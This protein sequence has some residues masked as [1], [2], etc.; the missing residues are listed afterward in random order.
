M[1]CR[2]KSGAPCNLSLRARRVKQPSANDLSPPFERSP[3]PIP[4]NLFT[5][6]P[7]PH[8]YTFFGGTDEIKLPFSHVSPGVFAT[9]RKYRGGTE[10][11]TTRPTFHCTTAGRCS[12]A[13]QRSG[14]IPRNRAIAR[15]GRRGMEAR[16][17]HADA[18]ALV[19]DARRRH[20]RSPPHRRTFRKS[21]YRPGREFHR[22][23]EHGSEAITRK[24]P[25]LA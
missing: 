17:L 8:P 23:L 10:A 9:R 12:L 20:G 16:R 18:N 25:T 6:N 13:G 7:L 21:I 5:G 14:F 15:P 11:E 1:G 24:L 3:V 4:P 22:G 19:P 2:F